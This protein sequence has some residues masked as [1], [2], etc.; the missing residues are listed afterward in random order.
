MLRVR[1]TGIRIITVRTALI[2]SPTTEVSLGGL[3]GACGE[4]RGSGGSRPLLPAKTL[5]RAKERGPRLYRQT[6]T[7]RVS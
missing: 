7:R 6:P 4:R 3:S 5:G 2:V 1:P